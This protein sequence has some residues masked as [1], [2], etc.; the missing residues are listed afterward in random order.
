MRIGIIT[1][2]YNLN[3]G[4]LL[5]AYALQKALAKLGHEVDIINYVDPNGYTSMKIF[6]GSLIDKA[7]AM[8]FLGKRLKRRK[9]FKQFI[10]QD[11]SLS[12]EMLRDSEQVN[13]ENLPYD[14]YI[15]GSDQ[16]FNLHLQG[17]GEYRK[18]YFLPLIK[19]RKIS[20]ASSMGDLFSNYDEEEKRWLYDQLKQYQ[21]LSVR[22]EAAADFIH[23]LGLERP[24]VDLDPTL[25]I[26]SDAWADFAKETKYEPGSYILFYSVLSAPWIVRNVEKLS[27]Q[28][29]LPVVAPHLMNRFEMKSGFIR[30]E[31]CGPK[32]FVSLIKNAAMVCTSSFHGT[33]FAIQFK[34]KFL[35]FSLSKRGR[36]AN[37]LKKL[38]LEKCIVTED[39]EVM[40]C[41]DRLAELDFTQAEAFLQSEREKST[42]YITEAIKETCEK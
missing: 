29:G 17:G 26:D 27:K 37:I 28:T 42:E 35:S 7:R 14:L 39:D 18:T 20:Y 19:D 6:G 11:L 22:E 21:I 36:I 34:K 32:E 1:L 33:A 15:T 5:Q 40:S 24:H 12:G 8:L 23:S 2:H 3:Y 38:H 41:A 16:T 4:A 30:A 31:E 25:L 13:A 10:R 9:A